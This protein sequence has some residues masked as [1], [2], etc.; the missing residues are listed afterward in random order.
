MDLPFLHPDQSEFIPIRRAGGLYVD[1]T[2]HL[3]RLLAPIGG[4]DSLLQSKYVFF[5]RPRR[6][7]KTLLVSTLEAFFQGNLPKLASPDKDSLDPDAGERAELFS[8]T[9]IEDVVHRSRVHPV[10]RL[11]MAMTASDTPERL[12]AKLL[13][14]LESVYTRWQARGVATGIDP[15]TE[16]GFI[17]FPP[18]SAGSN[19]VSA[20]GRLESLLHEL[21]RQ[22]DAPPVVLIDEYDAPLTHLLGRNL[23]PEPFISILREFFG[24]L[25]HLEDRLHFVFITGISR[26]AQMN[27]FSALN[28]LTDLSWDLDYSDLCGFSESDIRNY[29]LPYLQVGAANLGKPLEQVVQELR[30]HYNGYCFGHPGFS[31]NVYNPFSLLHCLRDM[32]A[33]SAGAKWQWLGWPNYWSESGTPRFLVQMIRNGDLALSRDPPPVHQ[34]MRTTYDLNNIDYGSLMLQTGYLTLRLD[35]GKRLRYDYPNNEVRLT[36]ASSLLEDFGR[37]ATTDELTGLHRALATENYEDFRTRLHTFMAGM[38]GEKIANETDCHL[39]L[40]ALCQLMRVEFQSEV[41]QLGGRSDLE[42]LF[43]NH[44]CVF[45]FKYNSS[46]QAALDQIEARD[47]GRRYFASERRVVAI[48]LNF[49]PG[50]SEEPPRIEYRTR[51][52]TLSDPGSSRS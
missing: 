42:V 52:R 4:N 7:G 24:L 17:R 3:R 41:H 13:A 2:D 21:E 20:A 44:I 40:H 14:H 9:A 46:P 38:P 22:F 12:H 18:P 29:L 19:S 50:S 45:E 10:V 6:F 8:G 48:G 31:K 1:K 51:V 23:D 16:G 15:W 37:Y 11:N 32:Q 27:L 33:A 5:A 30:E 28:N 25:K 34:L 35:Q 47:Y 43:P 26:F 39:S 36:F 49:I